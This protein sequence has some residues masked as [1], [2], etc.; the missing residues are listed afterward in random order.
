MLSRR[1]LLAAP[2]AIWTGASWADSPAFAVG[3]VWSL[4][5]PAHPGARILIGRIEGSTIHISLWGV[6]APFP[7]ATDV[8]GSPLVASHLPITATALL[9]SVDHIVADN[10]PSNLG[11][12]EGYQT[13]RREANGGVFTLTVPQIVEVIYETIRNG[14]AEQ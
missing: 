14:Q 1:T 12:E 13:W 11:F 9:E 10:P 4:R 3:Q 7:E 8:V 2:L 5:P 6:P